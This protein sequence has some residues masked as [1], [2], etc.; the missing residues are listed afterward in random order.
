MNKSDSK[1]YNTAIKM[2]EA[3]LQLLNEKDFDYIT[4]KEICLK[5]GVNRSTF[6]LHYETVGDLLRECI[7]YTNNKCFQ[8]YSDSLVNIKQKILSGKLNELLLITPEYMTPYLEF[9][10]ENK[11]LFM[12][13]VNHSTLM[14]ADETFSFMFKNIFSPILSRFNC[15]DMEKHYIISF[16]ISGIIA[17]I[18]AWLKND[19]KEETDTIVKICMKCVLP[20][21]E[22]IELYNTNN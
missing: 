12:A 22:L 6:Y 3:F 2:D 10:K 20:N 17:I 7:D 8:R 11:S 19:C 4:V 14:K 9:V 16:Y 5:A 1:Y 13:V 21:K 15:K 18:T